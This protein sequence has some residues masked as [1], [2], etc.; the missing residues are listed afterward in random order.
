MGEMYH[1]TTE[2]CSFRAR[3]SWS[4]FL[5]LAINVLVVFPCRLAAQES[6]SFQI[7]VNTLIGSTEYHVSN[8][9][10][11]ELAEINAGKFEYVF[12]RKDGSQ[13]LQIYLDV[14][15]AKSLA[16]SIKVTNSEPQESTIGTASLTLDNTAKVAELE[17]IVVSPDQQSKSVKRD[18]HIGSSDFE[19]EAGGIFLS[20][21]NA[22]GKRDI[23]VKGNNKDAVFNLGIWETVGDWRLAV[24][25]HGT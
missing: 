25:R 9:T 23:Q 20:V 14:S 7:E 15:V 5:L 4:L 18:N 21:K 2:K 16:L 22:N 17:W 12:S 3:I 1:K 24:K 19:I 13:D 6:N 8:D 11:R 10:Y